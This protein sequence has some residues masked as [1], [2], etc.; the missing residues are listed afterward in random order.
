MHEFHAL[1]AL[2]LPQV[3]CKMSAEAASDLSPNHS[4]KPPLH[5]NEAHALQY[6]LERQ[7]MDDQRC[8]KHHVIKGSEQ[9]LARKLSS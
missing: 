6:L 8:H 9:G 4:V 7:Q 5:R 1:F 2:D 3:D